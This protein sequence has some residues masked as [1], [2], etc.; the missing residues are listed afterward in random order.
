[1]HQFNE[2]FFSVFFL[3]L[4]LY[5][6]NDEGSVQCLYSA[7]AYLI[8][9]IFVTF[10]FLFLFLTMW[11]WMDQQTDGWTDIAFHREAIDASKNQPSLTVFSSSTT[12]NSSGVGE[13]F[14]QG[15]QN[16]I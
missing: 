8:Y 4:V 14:A 9:D 1:M 10:L 5:D 12:V 16:L 7:C 15:R 6:R 11:L 2:F 3:F 13:Q